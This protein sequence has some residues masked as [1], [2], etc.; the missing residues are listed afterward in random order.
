MQ[1]ST[2]VFVVEATCV[3]C[4]V[5]TESLCTMYIVF[6]PHSIIPPMLPNRLH[7]NT[8]LYQKDKR[9]NL[10]KLNQTVLFSIWEKLE[11]PEKHTH[12]VFF[13]LK[14]DNM[15][16]QRTPSVL[17]LIC[18]FFLHLNTL[19]TFGPLT[20]RVKMGCDGTRAETRFGLPAKRTSPFILAGVSV[21]SS[22][23]FLGVRV[24]GERL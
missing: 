19:V 4:E 20:G 13:I 11:R 8:V 10:G 3:L 1:H 15:I 22:T 17:C 14:V 7:L 6:Q 16:L 23:G 2:V 12:F 5:W 21:Q 24:G 9:T 18:F